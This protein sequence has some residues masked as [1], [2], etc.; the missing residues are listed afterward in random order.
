MRTAKDYHSALTRE[1]ESPA[2]ERFELRHAEGL[3]S[4]AIRHDLVSG[5]LPPEYQYTDV[6]YAEPPWRPGYDEFNRRAGVTGAPTYVEFL[7]HVN[8]V[9]EELHPRAVFLMLGKHATRHVLKPDDQAEMVLDT[10]GKA[11]C[12]VYAYNAVI[13]PP[14]VKG[15]PATTTYLLDYLARKATVLGDFTCG[16][17]YTARAALEHGKRFVVSDHNPRCIGFIAEHADCWRP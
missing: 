7:G 3:R 15:A 2:V 8:R 16:Y 14:P 12:V 13:P 1:R 6:I 5:P 11:R 10:H 17:G 4:Y 9:V